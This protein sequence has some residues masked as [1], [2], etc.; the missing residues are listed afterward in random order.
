MDKFNEIQPSR[1]KS[2]KVAEQ[3]IELIEKGDLGPGDKLPSEHNLAEKMGVSRPSVREA[4]SGLQALEIVDTR[5]GSGTYVSES[6]LESKLV[7]PDLSL[8]EKEASHMQIIEAR[9][10]LENTMLGI[11]INNFEDSHFEAVE[12]AL[13]RMKEHS[14]EKEYEDYMDADHDFHKALVKLTGN[15]LV[16]EAA[17]PLLATIKDSLYRELTHKYYLVDDSRIKRCFNTHQEL[18]G[19]IKDKDLEK[20]KDC[21]SRHWELMESALEKDD[22]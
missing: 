14:T 11:A 1:K 18:Y 2:V 19:A 6:I 10:F 15:P 16:V 12:E 21:I 3:I 4:L 5:T 8:M 9:K 22:Q 17:Q 7:S 20:A 13:S